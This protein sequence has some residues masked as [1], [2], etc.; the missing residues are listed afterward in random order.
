MGQITQF[1]IE[2]TIFDDSPYLRAENN[3]SDVADAATARDNLGI[4]DELTF[5]PVPSL[6]RDHSLAEGTS[7][8]PL[9]L[10][11]C[12]AAASDR[13]GDIVLRAD[14]SVVN[15]SSLTPYL[16]NN[17][18]IIPDHLRIIV[19]P[20]A[21]LELAAAGAGQYVGGRILFGKRGVVLPSGGIKDSSQDANAIWWPE[22]FSRYVHAAWFGAMGQQSEDAQP[23]I[24]SAANVLL[25][26]GIIELGV[27][28]YTLG[29][30][31]FSMPPRV[32][33]RGQGVDATRLWVNPGA[34]SLIG[35]NAR[36]ASGIAFDGIEFRP[37]TLRASDQ[38]TTLKLN[39][40]G[41]QRIIDCR[42]RDCIDALRI[43][44]ARNVRLERV[45]FV[46]ATSDYPQW[47]ASTHYAIGDKV[48]TTAAIDP[49]QTYFGWHYLCTQAGTSGST[50]P[51]G[52]APTDG[53][54]EWTLARC[55]GLKI[56]NSSGVIQA[57]GLRFSGRFTGLAVDLDDNVDGEAW[58]PETPYYEGD[59]VMDSGSLNGYVCV[60]SGESATTEPVWT[61][62]GS[63]I[64]DDS[65][66]WRFYSTRGM[67]RDILIKDI[68][69][70]QVNYPFQISGAINAKISGMRGSEVAVALGFGS[71]FDLRGCEQVILSDI[72]IFNP[73]EDQANQVG[74]DLIQSDDVPFD[75]LI[76]DRVYAEGIRY[77]M[78]LKNSGNTNWLF[79]PSVVLK[80]LVSRLD[81]RRVYDSDASADLTGLTRH[82]TP[83][84]AGADFSRDA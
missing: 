76:V 50:E 75:E 71:V 68:E 66:I 25:S 56:Y 65:V 73:D 61:T 34:S 26:G 2:T 4:K 9:T 60:Q 47:E 79:G 14:P 39:Y 36:Y 55:R 13:Y 69:M 17:P 19:M 38:A 28:D 74:A 32:T 83:A 57:S 45:E 6:S 43:S 41:Y 24:A 54:C 80:R 62:D 40:G 18:L 52:L 44:A 70:E 72:D 42:F 1:P 53:T 33:L 37:G 30:G 58:Q 49:T 12:I 5:F 29:S 15:A 22:S 20:G 8:N 84:V 11:D 78:R 82:T 31:D 67:S 7:E 48:I 46:D 3:L 35:I 23:A 59:R 64:H 10:Y 27:G 63:D 51:T 77:G 81:A 21:Q 16:L